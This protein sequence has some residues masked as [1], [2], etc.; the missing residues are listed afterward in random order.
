VIYNYIPPGH[1]T[2]QVAAG[3]N[4]G[5][6]NWQGQKLAIIVQPFIWQTWWFKVLAGL[7]LAA[8]LAWGV[9]RR[10]RWKARLRVERLEREH[11]VEHE[12]SRI[13]KDIH[14]DLGANLT[15]IVFL[16]QRVEGVRHQPSEVERWIRKIPAAASRTIQSLDEI[17]WA[18]NPKHDSL[19]SLANYL[20]RFAHDF[21]TLAGVRCLLEVP[22][23]LPQIPLSA[24][25][26]HNLILTAREA[27]QNAVTHAIAK[28]VKV[29]LQLNEAGLKIAVTD[30]G[31]GFDPG[32][33]AKP[34]N[35]LANMR[36]RMEDIGGTLEIISEPGKGTRVQLKL[37][38][39]RLT[40]PGIGK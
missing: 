38:A 12:R 27:L 37:P 17:V 26:R 4:D 33:V 10:E 2:F 35:G 13:A 39:H 40:Q 24:E 32:R 34:G 8:A 16:S 5:V 28:E 20:S 30:N 15:Q 11:A 31:C 6:W 36:K 21:L 29:S 25:G 22:T 1:Y 3:N 7:G 23:V 19:E 18:I 14:D 9:R